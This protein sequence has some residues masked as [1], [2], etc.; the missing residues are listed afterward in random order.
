L[1]A[2]VREDF[3]QEKDDDL[4]KPNITAGCSHLFSYQAACSFLEK[5]QLLGIVNGNARLDA[6]YQMYRKTSTG[7]PAVITIF[8]APNYLDAFNNKAAVLHDDGEVLSIRQFKCQEHPYCL[9]GFA[10]ALSWSLPFVVEKVVDFYNAVLLSHV[11]DTGRTLD[12][13]RTM[14][15]SEKAQR[16][17]QTINIIQMLSRQQ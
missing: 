8:S 4:F 5:S 17:R 12:N 15:V 10:N 9:P 7:F 13:P 3:G 1:W 14:P 6:G 2:K 16:I 11:E